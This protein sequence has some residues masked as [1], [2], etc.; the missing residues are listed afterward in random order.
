MDTV[1]SHTELLR[2]ALAVRGLTTFSINAYSRGE[3]HWWVDLCWV[4]N[5][6]PTTSGGGVLVRLTNY[7]DGT[8]DMVLWTAPYASRAV[9]TIEIKETDFAVLAEIA[10]DAF[11]RLAAGAPWLEPESAP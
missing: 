3:R 4:A 7:D 11:M 9:A 8:C 2:A 5:W 1:H 6:P 10:A